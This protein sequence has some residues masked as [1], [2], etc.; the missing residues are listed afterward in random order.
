MTGAS[1]KFQREIAAENLLPPKGRQALGRLANHVR[2]A[3]RALKTID[4][5]PIAAIRQ[6]RMRRLV[7]K[8]VNDIGAGNFAAGEM[9]Q[10][11]ALDHRAGAEFFE[12]L[13]QALAQCRL[14]THA[15][16][17]PLAL[18]K[19]LVVQSTDVLAFRRDQRKFLQ[20]GLVGTGHRRTQE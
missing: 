2:P 14:A 19:Y 4:D 7:E 13:I 18:V 15:H 20:R 8:F 16:P 17:Q 10:S 6:P 11:H 12:L 9:R 3:R 1:I 5:L